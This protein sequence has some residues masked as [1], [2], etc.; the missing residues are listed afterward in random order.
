MILFSVGLAACGD[1]NTPNLGSSEVG[2]QRL[3]GGTETDI[4]NSIQQTADGGYIIAGETESYGDSDRDF[5]LIKTD[6]VG[7]TTWTKSIGGV[8]DDRALCV[9]QTSD[10]GYI[11]TGILRSFSAG[12][13][14]VWLW[15]VD[16]DGNMSFIEDFG[17]IGNEVGSSV[18]Q[19]ADG[20]YIIAGNTTTSSADADIWLIK[21]DSGGDEEWSKRYSGVGSDYGDSVQQLSGVGYIITGGS[22]NGSGSCDIILIKTDASGNPT[23][24]KMFGGTGFDRGKSVQELSEGGFILV[25]ETTS[26]GAGGSDIWLI[27]TDSNLNEIWSKTFGGSGDEYGESVLQTSDGGFIIA[28]S[29]T[30]YGAGGSD[31]WLV[32]TDSGGNETWSKTFGDA[33]DDAGNAVIETSEGGF[34]ITGRIKSV[35]YGTSD[36]FLIVTNENGDI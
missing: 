27:K 6:A 3:Y 5:Y 24:N 17:G 19:T 21:T 16:S 13:T 11:V 1:I 25:G 34:A 23:S 32:K 36:I 10:G 9:R 29:T 12:G 8:D 31:V 26:Y 22:H 4:G 35:E 15:K 30:S 33:E 18:R 14:D 2:W 28:G 7:T 20:G